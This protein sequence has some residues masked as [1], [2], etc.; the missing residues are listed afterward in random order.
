MR[1]ILI[2]VL[3]F[4]GT[5][6]FAQNTE[7]VP[8]PPPPIEKNKENGKAKIYTSDDDLIFQK[9]EVESEFV[10]GLDA[11]R[12]FLIKNLKTNVP[13]KNG[14]KAGNYAVI[15]KFIVS[16]DGTIKDIELETNPGYGTGEEVVRV[17][18]KS[19]KWKPGY[20]NGVAVSSVKRQPITFAV[21][22]N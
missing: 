1:K 3:L 22:Y 12:N 19:P 10:G 4:I 14:A 17:M 15:V 6:G 16:K 18:K 11:W 21:S 9:V 8:P 2:L 13:G 20:Q 7:V 5:K